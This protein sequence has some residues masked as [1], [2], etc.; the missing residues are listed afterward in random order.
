[1]PK[2]QVTD[3]PVSQCLWS[4]GT[5][6]RMPQIRRDYLSSIRNGH[7]VRSKMPF[8]VRLVRSRPSCAARSHGRTTDKRSRRPD[9]LLAIRPLTWTS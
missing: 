3:G 7:L 6:E 4:N 5:K 8:S 9:R 1:M 2:P